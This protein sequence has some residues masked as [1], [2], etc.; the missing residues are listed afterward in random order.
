MIKFVGW[1]TPIAFVAK[2]PCKVEKLL[3]LIAGPVDKLTFMFIFSGCLG[4]V[5]GTFQFKS[6]PDDGCFWFTDVLKEN[7]FKLLPV[8]VFGALVANIYLIVL[9]SFAT[10]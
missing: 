5:A 9:K 6:K 4:C 1:L 10:G 2:S 8:F 7:W 3:S